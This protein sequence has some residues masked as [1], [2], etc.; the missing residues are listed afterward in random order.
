MPMLGDI[1]QKI[2]HSSKCYRIRNGL[3][4]IGAIY[5]MIMQDIPL[6]SKQLKIRVIHVASRTYE[7]RNAELICLSRFLYALI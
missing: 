5:S 4:N 7:I 2:S 3:K 1:D 6:E